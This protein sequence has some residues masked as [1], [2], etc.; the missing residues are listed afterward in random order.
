MMKM[1]VG[2]FIEIIC[3]RNGADCRKILFDISEDNLQLGKSYYWFNCRARILRDNVFGDYISFIDDNGKTKK[4]IFMPSMG[5]YN[6][7]ENFFVILKGYKK[8][9]ICVVEG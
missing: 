4:Q 3:N 1:K 9:T 7:E 5:Y 8:V 2:D 6:D